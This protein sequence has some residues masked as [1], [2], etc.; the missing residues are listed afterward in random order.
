MNNQDLRVQRTKKALI[1]TFSDLLETKSLKI[2][3][4]KIYAKK[5]MYVV[6]HF[7]VISMIS[8]IYLIILLVH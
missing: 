6:L 8:M 2:S 3:P 5:Q 1:T 4:F 7:T